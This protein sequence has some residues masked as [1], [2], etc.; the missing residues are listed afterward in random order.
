MEQTKATVT[1]L[2][3]TVIS[4][5]GTDRVILHTGLKQIL[6]PYEGDLCLTF[7]APANYG[8]EFVR[9][10]IGCEEVTVIQTK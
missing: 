5:G 6:W 9:N 2:R 7:E 3:A 4:S 8:E 1:I 10:V